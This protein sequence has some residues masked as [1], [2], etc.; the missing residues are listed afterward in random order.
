MSKTI[1][2]GIIEDQPLFLDGM[3]DAFTTQPDIAIVAHAAR[4]GDAIQ[5]LQENQPDVVIVGVSLPIDRFEALDVIV[6][7]YPSVRMLVLS[8]NSDEERICDAISGG[9]SGY[10]PR[11]TSGPELIDA[12][13]TLDQGIGC[14]SPTLASRLL[15]R[16]NND[17]SGMMKPKDRFKALAPRER[18]IVSML[19]VG[20]S[21]REIGVELDINEGT[22]KY[23]VTSI[24]GKLQVRNR[25]EAALLAR[26]Q[27]VVWRAGDEIPPQFDAAP[28]GKLARSE[29]AGDLSW[30]QRSDSRKN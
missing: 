29:S 3:I 28:P 30:L 21:N 9:L 22:V 12:V 1:R 24:L 27:G 5:L 13:R 19:A 8:D 26:S 2:I 7:K 20:L 4:I 18:Q 23:Y 10:L 16:A 25:V 6:S 15:M 17:S 14:V 11:S